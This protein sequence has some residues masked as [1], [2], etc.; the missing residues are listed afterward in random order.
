M[1]PK[2][3]LFDLDDT[4]IAFA[5]LADS[6]WNYV[7]DKFY[8]ECNLQS[9]KELF[10][11]IFNVR[12]WYWSSRERHKSGR[13]NLFETRRRIVNL[14]LQNI[15]LKNSDLANKIADTYSSH[16]LKLIHLFPKAKET[17]EYFKSKGVGLCLMTNGGAD[18]QRSKIKQF[19]LEEIFDVILVEGEIGFGKPDREV[20]VMAL[21][22]LKLEPNTVWS[23]GD[24]LEW[25]VCGPQQLGIYGI[26]NDVNK[27]GLPDSSKI[28]PDRIV[29]SIAELV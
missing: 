20:Y 10:E 5:C 26:W 29:H 11:I 25:D 14:A 24:N 8:K 27:K 3:I 15:G 16:S 22:S 18:Q 17:L 6:S 7:C 28:I 12:T 4:I 1:L 21:D 13:Q 19:G 23:V 9:S 2:G